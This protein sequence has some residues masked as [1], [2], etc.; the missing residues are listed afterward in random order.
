ML[1]IFVDG[2]RH[3]GVRFIAIGFAVAGFA[4]LIAAIVCTII[5]PYAKLYVEPDYLYLFIKDMGAYMNHLGIIIS[6]F[7]VAIG[8]ILLGVYISM[9]KALE[10]K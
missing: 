9:K 3:R 6:S 8:I 10:S 7:A 4:N 1:I 2:I 5:R